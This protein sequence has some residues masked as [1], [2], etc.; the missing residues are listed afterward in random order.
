MRN[1]SILLHTTTLL[2]YFIVTAHKILYVRFIKVPR[3]AFTT[4]RASIS[5]VSTECP[6]VSLHI[7]CETNWRLY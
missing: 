1:L 2:T 7:I 6:P 4:W 5:E 3:V